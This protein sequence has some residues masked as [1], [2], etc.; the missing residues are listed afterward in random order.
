[1]TEKVTGIASKT[2][3]VADVLLE[4]RDQHGLVP[5]PRGAL[6]DHELTGRKQDA[7][8]PLPQPAKRK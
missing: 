3:T 1:M 7:M 4:F 2:R 8:Q 5:F 6:L